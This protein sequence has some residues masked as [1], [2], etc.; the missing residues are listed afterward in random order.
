[1]KLKTF[2]S[3]KPGKSINNMTDRSETEG[4]LTAFAWELV[5]SS[6]PPRQVVSLLL[7]PS[8]QNWAGRIL[9]SWGY[10]EHRE[11]A[12]NEINTLNRYSILPL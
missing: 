5:I 2:K 3:S 12:W 9:Q 4:I 1:M 8:T 6:S 7:H 10:T 11:R